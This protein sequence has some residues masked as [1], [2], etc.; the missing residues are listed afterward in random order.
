LRIVT[1]D[2]AR[3]VHEYHALTEFEEELR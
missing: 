1:V 2:G 3:I